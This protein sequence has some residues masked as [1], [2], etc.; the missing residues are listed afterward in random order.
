[1]SSRLFPDFRVLWLDPGGL[2]PDFATPTVR[3]C[4]TQMT[5]A[6][7]N[8]CAEH[9]DDPFACPDMLIAYSA[10][11]DEYGLVVHDGGASTVLIGHCPWCGTRLPESQRDRWF[12][13]LE[14]L[15]FDDPL[16]DPVPARYRSAAWR[17]DGEE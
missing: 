2:P 6:L 12:D 5:N 11:F 4:C 17:Q 8:D 10:V 7:E 13:A 16:V 9:A 15:G 1:M 3:H 14:A